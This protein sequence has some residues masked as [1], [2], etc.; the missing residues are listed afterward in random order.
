MMLTLDKELRLG[1]VPAAGWYDAEVVNIETVLVNGTETKLRFAFRLDTGHLAYMSCNLSHDPK[2]NLARL[3]TTLTG[4]DSATIRLA[5]LLGKR[6]RVYVER[7]ETINRV[8]RVEGG[9]TDGICR[10]TA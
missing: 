6:C 4:K 5:E 7:Y 9:E 2:S 8:F 1:F 3:W 10:R